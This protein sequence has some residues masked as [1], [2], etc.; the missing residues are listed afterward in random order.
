MVVGR[1]RQIVLIALESVETSLS[2]RIR[3]F[4][5]HQGFLNP[6]FFRFGAS[7][8]SLLQEAD[9]LANLCLAPTGNL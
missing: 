2:E 7:R 6:A 8:Q 9:R 4:I 5:F 1:Y 3:T